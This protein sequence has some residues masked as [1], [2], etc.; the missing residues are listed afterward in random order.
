MPADAT[1][2]DSFAYD[3]PVFDA[4][5]VAA[6]ALLPSIQAVN[7]TWFCGAWAGNGFHEDGVNS[8]LAVAQSFGV[9]APW[10]QS[11]VVA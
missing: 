3:H 8:A 2:I 5:A 4:G 10:S 6:Q 7:R 11:V 9:A 1:L